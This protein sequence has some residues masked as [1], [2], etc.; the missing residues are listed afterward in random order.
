MINLDKNKLINNIFAIQQPN[1]LSKYFRFVCNGYLEK[2]SSDK[3][4][5]Y[6]Y[7]NYMLSKIDSN[8]FA[9]IVLIV[10]QIW[11]MMD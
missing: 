11:E 5:R 3:K 9:D 6:I 7:I 1:S 8:R 10:F 4:I 2:F